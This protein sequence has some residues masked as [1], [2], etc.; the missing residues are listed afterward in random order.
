MFDIGLGPNVLDCRNVVIVAD[1]VFASTSCSI[2]QAMP[3]P[4]LPAFVMS[5]PTAVK[6]EFQE[7]VISDASA[8]AS[9]RSIRSS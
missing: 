6:I 8:S 3:L 2:F 9:T 7:L 4:P 5:G 1:A